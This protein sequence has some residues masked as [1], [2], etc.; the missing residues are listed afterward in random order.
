PVVLLYH[1]VPMDESEP[2]SG[3]AFEQQLA[4]L[5][6]HC[7]FVSPTQ[8]EDRRSPYERLRVVLTFDDGF[9]NNAD[10]AAPILRRYG[11]PALFFV[12]SRHATRGKYLWF[13]YL[14]ALERFYP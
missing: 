3:R 12:S 10:V 9:R 13:S 6:K 1:G 8:I 5:S 2:V 4:F 11:V 7:E 14:R